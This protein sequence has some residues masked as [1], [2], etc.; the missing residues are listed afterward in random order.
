MKKFFILIM[1]LAL[2][3]CFDAE[4]RDELDIYTS[5]YP[6]EFAT[7]YLYGTNSNVRSIYPDG[8]DINEYDLTEKQIEEYSESDLF[9]FNSLSKEKE[10]VIPM[11]LHNRNFQIIDVA[12]TIDI[13]YAQEEIWLDPSNYLKLVKNINE[14]LLEIVESHYLQNEIIESHKELRLEIANLSAQLRKIGQSADNNN[15]VI[16]DDTFHFLEKYGFNVISLADEENISERVLFDIE[17]LIA[18]NQLNYIYKNRFLETNDL[19]KDLVAKHDLEIV[20]L[21]SLITIMEEERNNDENYLTITQ[22]NIAKL[23]KQIR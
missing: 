9:I 19:V 6:I 20:E 11:Y 13:I 10:Y 15:L 14:G 17:E 23:T 21:H 5:I 12:R 8:I 1:I 3:G 2:S 7:R 16:A 4:R 18:N 22:E